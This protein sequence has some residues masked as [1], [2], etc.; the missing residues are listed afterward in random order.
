[1]QTRDQ[2][3]PTGEDASGGGFT[4]AA[5]QAAEREMNDA[6][7]RISTAAQ[8]LRSEATGAGG[9]ISKLVSEQ[10]ERRKEAAADGL[11]SFADAI[12][13]AADDLGESD[14]SVSA[15]LVQEAAHGLE[16]LSGGLQSQSVSD[17]TRSLTAFGRSNPTTFLTGCLLAGVAIGRFLIASG[18]RAQSR[19]MGY[20]AGG[21]RYGSGDDAWRD[22]DRGVGSGSAGVGDVAGAG[23]G[24]GV[25]YGSGAGSTS[26]VGSGAAGMGSGLGSGSGT[27]MGS[28]PGSGV[29]GAAGV[30]GAGLSGVGVAGAGSIDPTGMGGVPGA[31]TIDPMSGVGASRQAG[32]FAG[33]VVSP[34]SVERAPGDLDALGTST[35]D[36]EPSLPS[37]RAFDPA[38]GAG[39][40]GPLDPI[41]DRTAEE[42]ASDVDRPFGE[43]NRDKGGRDGDL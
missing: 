38:F 15:R 25:D 14:R 28:G 39:L 20:G 1:M 43:R 9:T 29:G 11:R 18:A 33:D 40:A 41:D 27:G 35:D 36:P 4:A 10:A 7:A 13:R 31:G 8:D 2:S 21:R 42:E 17:M 34:S 23:Y 6:R 37:D 19:E 30:A 24:S 22:A 26:G 12:R 32:T 5:K 16:R 3:S